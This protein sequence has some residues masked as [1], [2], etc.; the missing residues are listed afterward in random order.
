MFSGKKLERFRASA[1]LSCQELANLIGVTEGE[2]LAWEKGTSIPT[3]KQKVAL[4]EV[5]KV[6]VSEIEEISG[7][8]SYEGD[9]LEEEDIDEIKELEKVSIED[10]QND[11]PFAQGETAYKEFGWRFY[12][13]DNKFLTIYLLFWVA[14]FLLIVISSVG[15]GDFE[16]AGLMLYAIAV[17]FI[18]FGAIWLITYL[19]KRR[20]SELDRKIYYRFYKDF[21]EV[22][23]SEENLSYNQKVGY[24]QVIKYK[25][26]GRFLI[27]YLR[28]GRFLVDFSFLNGSVKK[29]IALLYKTKKQK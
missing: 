29:L 2:I 27:I 6:E 23:V 15:E 3:Q 9:E 21:F 26:K 4:A 10:L 16:G 24:D 22:A 7:D 25:T 14:L 20:A 13:F 5:L 8:L 19:K 17:F 28:Q 1:N 18:P 12:W 11:K